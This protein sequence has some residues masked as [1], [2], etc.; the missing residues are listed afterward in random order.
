MIRNRSSG[1][2][3]LLLGWNKPA[4]Y[5]RAKRLQQAGIRVRVISDS[6]NLAWQCLGK[7]VEVFDGD[8]SNPAAISRALAGAVAVEYGL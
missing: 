6:P 3:Y 1:G 2:T 5:E 8:E 7:G 4:G